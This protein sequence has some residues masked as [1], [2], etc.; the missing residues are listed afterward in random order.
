MGSKGFTLIEA[1][2][3]L[4]VFAV[5]VLA[6][7]VTQTASLRYSR[8]AQALQQEVLAVRQ[9]AEVLRSKPAAVPTLCAQA[10]AGL[11]C[12]SV[13]C[14]LAGEGLTCQAGGSSPVAYQVTLSDRIGH[15]GLYQ[16]QTLIPLDVTTGSAG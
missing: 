2:I 6:A 4:F 9:F 11:T 1:M 12:Q 10:P 3:A 16:I 5:A 8:D 14:A 7:Y 15:A 13:P